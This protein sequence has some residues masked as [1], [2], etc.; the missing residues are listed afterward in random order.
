MYDALREANELREQLASDRRRIAF[1]FGAGTSQAVGIPGTAALTSRVPDHLEATEKDHYERIL[2]EAG[3]S[4]TVEQVLDTVRL[5]RELIGDS[6]DR[7]AGGFKGVA[8][9][10]LDRAI[11]RAIFKL[12]SGDPPKG[13]APHVTFANWV[14]SVR[15]EG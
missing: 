13:L 4:A 3:A 1:L 2:R 8:A 15:R 7:E 11:C 6:T 12:V 9:A 14:R 10:S 5:C